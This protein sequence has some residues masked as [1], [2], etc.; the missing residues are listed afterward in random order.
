[1]NPPEPQILQWSV[2]RMQRGV[3]K[4]VVIPLSNQTY[5]H[6]TYIKASVWKNE[7]EMLLAA[8]SGGN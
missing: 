5:G 1:M 4:A 6:G 8:T 7:L 2:A 3:G